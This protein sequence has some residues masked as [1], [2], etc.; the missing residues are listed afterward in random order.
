MVSFCTLTWKEST[1]LASTLSW[2][3]S[4]PRASK[5][6]QLQ[7]WT[8]PKEQP[9]LVNCI[10]QPSDEEIRSELSALPG[11][12]QVSA[13]E[14]RLS[15]THHMAAAGST[16]EGF[17]IRYEEFSSAG[18]W[19]SCDDELPLDTACRVVVEYRNGSAGWRDHIAWQ[20]CSMKPELAREKERRDTR[21]ATSIVLKA[22]GFVSGFIDAGRKKR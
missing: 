10:E 11:G 4:K 12:E 8:G 13:V 19:E 20:R 6:I 17:Y 9:N 16:A 18:R 3:M 14:L 15:K 7:T 1:A 2:R 5:R 22:V 21:D